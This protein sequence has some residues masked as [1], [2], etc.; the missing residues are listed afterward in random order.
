LIEAEAQHPRT[1]SG[2]IAPSTVLPERT[3]VSIGSAM[4]SGKME[5]N[6]CRSRKK[7]CASAALTADAAAIPADVDL[8]RQASS[9][10]RAFVKKMQ[11]MRRQ[12]Q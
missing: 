1:L 5:K 8:R 10:S 7:S 12:H 4:T 2:G 3:V 9:G 6:G 11:R